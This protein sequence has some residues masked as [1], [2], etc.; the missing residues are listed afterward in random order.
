MIVRTWQGRTTSENAE[1]YYRH[2]VDAV[3][4]A[5]EGIPGHRGALLLRREKEPGSG[6]EFLVL[7]FWDSMDAVRAFA[8][9]DPGRAV[10]EPAARAVLVDFDSSVRHYEAALDTRSVR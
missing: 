9:P 8:G 5:L 10:V 7:T 1:A 2:L 3:R 4:P 6:T